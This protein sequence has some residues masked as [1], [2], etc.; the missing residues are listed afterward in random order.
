MKERCRTPCPPCPAP[1]PLSSQSSSSPWR[2]GRT[3]SGGPSCRG[4]CPHQ[5]PPI[6]DLYRSPHW[7]GRVADP[8]PVGSGPFSSEPDPEYFHRI[9]ILPW[10]CKVVG[11]SKDKYFFNGAFSQFQLNFAIYSG[12]KSYVQKSV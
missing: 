8:D 12:K 11:I 6:R 4:T 10:L 7:Y 5:K 3:G 9:R 2:R 1:S